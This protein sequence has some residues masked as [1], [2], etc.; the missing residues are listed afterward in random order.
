MA[1]VVGVY[2]S[3]RKRYDRGL[4]SRQHRMGLINRC[5]WYGRSLRLRDHIHEWVDRRLTEWWGVQPYRSRRRRIGLAIAFMW[6]HPR[7]VTYHSFPWPKY[8]T[9]RRK[10]KGLYSPDTIFP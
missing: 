1:R 10:I 3:G 2:K 4:Q 7:W 5:V 6:N 8:G 9:G